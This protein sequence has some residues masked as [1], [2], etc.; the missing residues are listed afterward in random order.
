VESVEREYNP[1]SLD[2]QWTRGM[3][4]RSCRSPDDLAGLQQLLE[5]SGAE[6]QLHAVRHHLRDAGEMLLMKA[7]PAMPSDQATDALA[8]GQQEAPQDPAPVQPDSAA[9][10]VDSSPLAVADLM[11]TTS[12]EP[13]ELLKYEVENQPWHTPLPGTRDVRSDELVSLADEIDIV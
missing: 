3:L 8:L 12:A 4:L 7:R 2:G 13:G 11:P 1:D 9:S 6:P 10:Q 5:Q